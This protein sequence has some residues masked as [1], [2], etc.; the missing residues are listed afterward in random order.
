MKTYYPIVRDQLSISMT[1]PEFVRFIELCKTGIPGWWRK[2]DVTIE[3]FE[4]GNHRPTVDVQGEPDQTLEK[5]I[6]KI[7]TVIGEIIY[8]GEW[9]DGYREEF[10]ITMQRAL[11]LHDY[12]SV[13]EVPGGRHVACLMRTSIEE[14]II[15]YGATWVFLHRHLGRDSLEYIATL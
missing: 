7:Q 14:D 9:R 4:S 11:F 5:V 15:R 12:K 3:V 8:V 1:D 13:E 10:P 2:N 6:A